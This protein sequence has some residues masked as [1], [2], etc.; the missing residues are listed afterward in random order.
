VCQQVALSDT[1]DL[2]SAKLISSSCCSTCYSDTIYSTPCFTDC[3]VWGRFPKYVI[4]KTI[5]E[6]RSAATIHFPLR[7][8]QF[9]LQVKQSYLL[10]ACRLIVQPIGTSIRSAILWAITQLVVVI[11]YRRFE[12]NLSVPSSRVKNQFL[13]LKDGTHRISRNVGT[14]LA[15]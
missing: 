8:K 6:A 5:S 12:K 10:S 7:H 15:L 2:S 11:P 1:A 13:T 14:E 9:V 4:S 3:S